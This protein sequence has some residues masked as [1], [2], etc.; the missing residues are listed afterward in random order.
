MLKNGSI[1]NDRY[2]II[3]VVGSGGMSDVYKAKCHKLNRYVAIKVL[4]K[5][6]SMDKSFVSKFRGEA[7]S[8][9]GFSNPNIVNI[10]DVCEDNGLYYIV[11]ELVEGITLKAYIEKK[12]RLDVRESVSIAI[13]IAQGIKAAHAHHIIHRDIKPQNILIS[14]D[15]KVKVTDFGIARVSSTQTI[16]SNAMGSVHYISPEQARGGYVDER[17]DIYSL[18]ITLYEMLTGQVPFQSDTAVSVALMHIQNELPS[19]R[20]IVPAIPVDIE[21]IIYK[22]T[23]KKIDKRYT[24]AGALIEDLKAALLSIGHEND[25]IVAKATISKTKSNDNKITNHTMPIPARRVAATAAKTAAEKT[26]KKDFLEKFSS[27]D[28]KKNP[29]IERALTIAVVLIAIA[30]IVLGVYSVMLIKETL[31]PPDIIIP[32]TDTPTPSG[33][34]QLG[35]SDVE[36]PDLRNYTQ[37][38]AIIELNKINLKNEID[39]AYS[40]TVAKGLVIS[41]QYKEGTLLERNTV[42][43][44]VISLGPVQYEITDYTGKTYEEVEAILTEHE[45]IYSPVFV[46]DSEVPIGGIIKTEPETGEIL[47]SGATVVVYISRGAEYNSVQVP[48]IAGKTVAEALALLTQSGLKLRNIDYE[49][50]ENVAEGIIMTQS[51]LTNTVV[52]PGTEVDITVSLGKSAP[53]TSLTLEKSQFTRFISEEN[54]AFRIPL[55]PGASSTTVYQY[56]VLTLELTQSNL[57]GEEVTTIIRTMD[58]TL[59]QLPMHIDGIEGLIGVSDGT[60]KA[61]LTLGEQ[62]YTIGSFYVEFQ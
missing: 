38:D 55:R 3:G 54:N 26:R 50:S 43:R 53:T 35:I 7:Q 11:M 56:A 39:H 25:K 16:N 10:Y 8:A 20:N 18:G 14:K 48:S 31:T 32:T 34:S 41:Q 21:K 28:K 45:L 40:T 49:N 12:G 6:Y 46:Y 13:Q 4:K 15:G 2:E 29:I 1:L 9:A 42:V 24:D 5:E 62:R 37:N 51:Y 30:I 19:P 57:N 58:I 60:I 22:C 61:Y 52:L 59:E 33:S 17:S 27:D 47:S 23:E 44:L 36:M